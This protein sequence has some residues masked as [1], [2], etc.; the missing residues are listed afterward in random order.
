MVIK[1]LGNEKNRSRRMI[2]GNEMQM[3]S[4]IYTIDIEMR[5][6]LQLV[7]ANCFSFSQ[8]KHT[9]CVNNTTLP[10]QIK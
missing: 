3:S 1:S 4:N 6:V 2:N 10:V 8:V 5:F 9:L 7:R